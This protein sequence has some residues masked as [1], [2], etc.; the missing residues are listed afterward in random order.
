MGG[1]L[2]TFF[3]IRVLY[4]SVQFTFS[5]HVKHLK[6]NLTKTTSLTKLG[7]EIRTCLQFGH[8]VSK[9]KSLF[10]KSFQIREGK[11]FVSPN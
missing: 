9:T 4:V 8:K 6:L 11:Y 5:F 3:G 1:A 10:S 7:V 2:V